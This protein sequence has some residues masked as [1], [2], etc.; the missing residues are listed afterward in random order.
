MTPL[1]E[2][3]A[4]FI[5]QQWGRAPRIG[6]I[7]GTGL[8]QAARRIEVEC[9]LPYDAIPHFPRSTAPGHPGRLLCGRL[10]QVPA[11]AMAGRHHVYEGYS[12]AQITLPIQVLGALGVELLMLSNASGGL[13]PRFRS[14]DIMVLVDHIQW[15][16]RRGEGIAEA[17]S[18]DEHRP[19]V[20]ADRGLPGPSFPRAAGSP[21]VG[22]CYDP[23]LIEEALRIARAENLSVHRGVYVAVTGPNYETRAEYRFLRR[24]GGDAVGMS[25][26]PEAITAACLGMRVLALSVIANVAVPV[27]PERTESQQVTAWAARGA[28]GLSTILSG[29]A[30]GLPE[31]GS[32]S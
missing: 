27:A 12:F 32:G 19:P 17:L 14:G 5:R 31:K 1:V 6:I 28:P 22:W 10:A 9:E 23:A 4:A 30:A 18:R 15:M 3:A 29:L 13:N 16:F 11:I 20:A 8:R 24:I 25:T 7:L 21:G 2:Q 26:V